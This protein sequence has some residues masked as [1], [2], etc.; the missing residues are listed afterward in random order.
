VTVSYEAE[1]ANV[2]SED[3]IRKILDTLPVP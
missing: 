1:A 3:V 2:T